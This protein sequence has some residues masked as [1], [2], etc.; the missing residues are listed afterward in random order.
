MASK[1][2]RRALIVVIAGSTSGC[3]GAFVRPTP[4]P[5]T[6]DRVVV[7][8]AYLD[9]CETGCVQ[10]RTCLGDPEAVERACLQQCGQ[11]AATLVDAACADALVTEAACFA[12][13]DCS[14]LREYFS[15]AP[16]V[17]GCASEAAEVRA[18]CPG[19]SR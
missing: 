6:P 16:E 12:Q 9:A 4:P 2:A 3:L 10:A 1:L 11:T 17:S 18:R 14:A 13:L 15:D 5:P 8:Q 19:D 7:Q